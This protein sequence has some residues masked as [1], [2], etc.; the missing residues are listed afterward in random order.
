MS[1]PHAPA[2][3]SPADGPFVRTFAVTLILATGLV[4]LVNRVVDPLGVFGTGWLPPVVTADRDQKAALFLARQPAPGLVVLGSSRSKTLDPGCLTRLTGLPAFNFAV[5]GADAADLLAI[6]R[7]TMDRRPGSVRAF[8][9]GVE[10][11]L[12]QPGEAVERPLA[13]SRALA[14]YAPGGGG[15]GRAARLAGDLLGWQA[16]GA[17]GRSLWRAA[18]APA[19]PAETAL[20]P[21]GLQRYPLADAAAALVWLPD[22]ARI[23]RSIPGVL[24]RYVAFPG[25][26][27]GRVEMLRRFAREAG[28]AGIAVTAFIPPV[29]P[30]LEAAA[31]SA[32]N[33]RAAESVALLRGLEQEGTLRYVETRALDPRDS[34]WFV[35]AIHFLAPAAA[36]LAERIAGRPDGCAIQ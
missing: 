28:A 36:R 12:L 24:D 35:D 33:A 27:S 34:G 2:E 8:W 3:S 23:R 4:A 20:E 5:N 13:G 9:V 16:V 17:A 1:H 7:F 22:S 14:G 6:A 19:T 11:E 15:P 25:L 26:D 29:H 32:W 10:P 21:D 18:T 31:G 30:S